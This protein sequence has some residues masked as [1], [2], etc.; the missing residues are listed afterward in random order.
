MKCAFFIRQLKMHTSLSVFKLQGRSLVLSVHNILPF[1]TAPYWT[2]IST[3]CRVRT[4]YPPCYIT[5]Q[6]YRVYH[7]VETGAI[8]TAISQDYKSGSFRHTHTP[9]MH[10][11]SQHCTLSN[12]VSCEKLPNRIVTRERWMHYAV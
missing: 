7:S 2:N 3:H 6:L 8:C 11:V 1:H 9:F 12:R 4:I 10:H 5:T